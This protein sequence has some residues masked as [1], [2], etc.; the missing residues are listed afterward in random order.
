MNS[1][2]NREAMVE[3]N[4]FEDTA[5]IMSMTLKKKRIKRQKTPTKPHRVVS[6]LQGDLRKSN[7]SIHTAK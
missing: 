3:E 6:T 1:D 4:T 2:S 7:F 5:E